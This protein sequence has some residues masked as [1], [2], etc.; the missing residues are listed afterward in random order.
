M[1]YA[2]NIGYINRITG[3]A[4]SHT[5]ENYRYTDLIP[6][7]GVTEI[8]ANYTA[9]WSTAGWAVY[10]DDQSQAIAGGYN[11]DNPNTKYTAKEEVISK[12]ELLDTMPDAKYIRFGTISKSYDNT[13]T[14]SFLV[15]ISTPVG[16]DETVSSLEDQISLV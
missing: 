2:T 16:V 10:N 15:E 5:D 11:K 6:L 8:T 3:Q 9:R 7:D 12:A 1:Y 14:N 4:V 13:N